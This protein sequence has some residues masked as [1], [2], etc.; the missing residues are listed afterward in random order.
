MNGENTYEEYFSQ[1]GKTSSLV[2]GMVGM[3]AGVAG[4]TA[5]ALADKNIRREIFLKANI[6]KTKLQEWSADKIQE[7]KIQEKTE[8]V[9]EEAQQI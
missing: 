4:I 9:T 3:I 7:S 2:A 8:K 6:L 5:I 1:A